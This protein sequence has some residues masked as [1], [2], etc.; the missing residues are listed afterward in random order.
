MISCAKPSLDGLIYTI[1]RDV[2]LILICVNTTRSIILCCPKPWLKHRTMPEQHV[3][4]AGVMVNT[5][6]VQVDVSQSSHGSADVI[7]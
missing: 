7:S 5:Q 1:Q 4:I 3:G 6:Y 2:R